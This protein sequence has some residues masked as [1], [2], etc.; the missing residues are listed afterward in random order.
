M[1]QNSERYLIII[2]E[3]YQNKTQN[4]QSKIYFY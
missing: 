3:H 4:L 2:R 1:D